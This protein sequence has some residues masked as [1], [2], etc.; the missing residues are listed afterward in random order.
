ML[1]NY[2]KT[3]IRNFWGNKFFSFVNIIGL[4]IGISA[5]LV[6]YM[7]VQ[8]DFTFDKFEQDNNRIYRVVSNFSFSGDAHTTAGV[9]YPMGAVVQNE[10]TGIDEVAAFKIWQGGYNGIKVSVPAPANN[11]FTDFKK[12]EPVVFADGNY[13]KLFQYK[14]LAG[15]QAAALQKP[16]QVVLTKRN[17][18]LYF[19][20]VAIQDIIGRNIYFNDTIQAAVTGIV[21]DIDKNTDLVF[22]IFFS[23]ITLEAPRLM[24][25][26]W[27]MWGQTDPVSQL[28]IKLSATAS[29]PQVE[30]QLAIMEKKY[31]ASGGGPG[32][33]LAYALQPLS[34]IH[35][36]AAYDNFSGRVASKPALYG[37][38]A[39]AA[40]LLLLACINF[41]N[42][43]TA[44]A[45][46]RAKEIGIR[47]TMGSTK[48]QLLLQF[49]SE[50]FLLTLA[51]TILSA[52]LTPLLLKA[53]A[54]FIPQGLHVGMLVRPRTV[55]FLLGIV[56]SVSLLAGFYP[57]I[58]LSSYNPVVVLKSKVFNG[59]GK[60]GSA[61]MRKWLT[62]AQFV[63]AQFFIIGSIAVSKQ[64]RFSLNADMGFKK[65]A[66]LYFGTNYGND[67]IHRALLHNKLSAIPG[68][69]MVSL[70]NTAATSSGG[71][72][73]N[74][75][76]YNTG[77]KEATVHVNVKLADTNYLKLY[78]IQLLAG[79]NLPASDTIKDILVN[80]TCARMLG[81]ASPQQAIGKYITW[82]NK[83]TPIVGVVADF[84]YR[85]LHE[86]VKP[87]VIS[88]KEGDQLT[89]NIALQPQ[90]NNGTEWKSTISQIAQA[91][92]QVYPDDVFDYTFIDDAVAKY[93]DAEQNIAYL[94]RWVT[95][96][97]IFISCLG[98]LGLIIY[99]T[100][101]RTREIGIRKVVG[102]TVSQ[103]VVLLS[104]D[105]LKLVL[106]AFVVAVPIAWW[107]LH[108]WLQN[109]AY[110]TTLSWWV[111][112][113]G[114]GIIF[115]VA[116][117]ILCLRT[118]KAAMMN[119]VESLR[120]E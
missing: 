72:R 36:N 115:T 5:S 88:S 11:Q 118:I 108:A 40:F 94:L 3:A 32:V 63:I 67:D 18:S 24:P 1:K 105:F 79:T 113:T 48:R 17:A 73:G 90:G 99:I 14:W 47:K 49:L 53:F 16:Y 103:L 119:P 89:F 98:L 66:I 60:A 30:K 116:L 10:V 80:E 92:K 31:N 114:G 69:A 38:L 61:G 120:G 71:M 91:Y 106:A 15:S 27:H 87:L 86:E 97:S 112:A 44:Q 2:F 65:E 13:F 23:R 96:L 104:K 28:F 9:P 95:A 51:A 78:H 12:K 55:L 117:G 57:A 54:A 82:E 56:V 42:L 29:K 19:P 102:A 43:T 100:H 70:S 76:T 37:L 101:Q 74:T 8:Y 59:T 62:T 93:Y 109:F 77:G 6:I 58:V 81:F 68:I 52:G 21:A 75:L 64:V 39:A 46:Q 83:K 22:N 26:A 4:A 111:F 33:S 50:T 110:K 25:Y 34:D 20:H 35:F 7:L 107:C 84:N 85:S 41:I 45:T